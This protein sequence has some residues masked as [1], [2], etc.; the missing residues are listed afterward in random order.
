M[1]GSVA[2]ILIPRAVGLVLCG[3]LHRR[4]NWIAEIVSVGTNCDY[5]RSKSGV[6]PLWN[7]RIFSFVSFEW[8]ALPDC[9]PEVFS[10]RLCD[11]VHVDIERQAGLRS[12]SAGH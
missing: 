8:G 3:V 9:L 5:R 7:G 10:L 4:G 6:W 12:A 2:P 1:R 11:V